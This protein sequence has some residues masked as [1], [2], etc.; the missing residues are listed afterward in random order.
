M[1]ITLF[2]SHCGVFIAYATDNLPGIPASQQVELE[3]EE[4]CSPCEENLK[5]LKEAMERAERGRKS[6]AAAGTAS[7]TQ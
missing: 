2:F 1:G 5:R 3:T 4:E 7:D 6:Q